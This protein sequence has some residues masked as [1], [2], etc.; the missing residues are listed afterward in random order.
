MPIQ[1]A[2]TLAEFELAFR[3]DPLTE[4][5]EIKLFYRD[6]LNGLRDA[7]WRE[8][9]SLRLQFA[10]GG[11]YFRGAITGHEGV[12]K[13]TEMAVLLSDVQ[14]DFKVVRVD[15]FIDLNPQQFRVSDVFLAIMLN[16]L[17]VSGQNFNAGLRRD[18]WNG[19]RD[20]FP[21]Y[22]IDRDHTKGAEAG[23]DVEVGLPFLV[24]LK[25]SI[26][27]KSDEK[28][29]QPL[30]AKRMSD[31]LDLLNRILG[32][33]S[34]STIDQDILIYA[35]NFEKGE[36]PVAFLQEMFLTFGSLLRSLD[37]HLLCS[38]PPALIFSDG[39]ARLPFEPNEITFL[40]DIPV[41]NED[42]QPHHLGIEAIRA[43]VLARAEANLFEPGQI[44]AL[45]RASG[46]GLR[47]LF[48]LI[49]EAGLEAILARTS[50][51]TELAAR[52]AVNL[53]IA[54]FR[55]RLGTGPYDP[56]PV[57]WEQKAAKLKEVYEGKA[58]APDD[59]L[60][61]LLRSRAVLFVNGNGRYAVHPIVVDIL[62]DAK[63]LDAKC[64]GGVRPV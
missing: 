3:P 42:H 39:A 24:K 26:K 47:F 62:R 5:D 1:K 58:V 15:A 44:D 43:V 30:E 12:G 59:T 14:K 32:V 51:V 46:G 13:T 29:K 17:E 64:E 53:A 35:D 23:A 31:L 45:I 19:I 36:I 48:S 61:A 38:L 33:C 2:T 57:T 11:M 27:T 8:K 18:V 28:Q 50:A 40:Y 21:E 7:R 56:K 37:A 6:D 4:P 41:L 49:R 20:F 25:G 10:K 9:M 16:L 54:P 52:R 22:Q 34:R 63:I 55:N 60:Y